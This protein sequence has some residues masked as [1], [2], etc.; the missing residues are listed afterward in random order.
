MKKNEIRSFKEIKTLIENE[1]QE[2]LGLFLQKDFKSE[3]SDRWEAQNKK[4]P[5][6]PWI[7]WKPVLIAGCLFLALVLG[8]WIVYQKLTPSSFEKS[9]AQIEKVLSRFPL[10][11]KI[12]NQPAGTFEP[13]ENLI[14]EWRKIR[15]EKNLHFFF[16]QILK[17]FKEV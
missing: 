2:S 13:P 16:S 11:A 12:R 15:E 9:V 1:K 6:F 10:D 3:L 14:R 7:S 5:T 4:T 8:S 17:H